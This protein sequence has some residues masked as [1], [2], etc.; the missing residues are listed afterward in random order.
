MGHQPGY[1]P[2]ADFYQSA[3]VTWAGYGDGTQK[4]KA[5]PLVRIPF[6]WLFAPC[7]FLFLFAYGIVALVNLWPNNL[8]MNILTYIKVYWI[9]GGVVAGL[10]LLTGMWYVFSDAFLSHYHRSEVSG[11]LWPT[12]LM[13]LYAVVR[14]VG[15]KKAY[16]SPDIGFIQPYTD[17]L[18][19]LNFQLWSSVF[20]FYL[21]YRFI[22]TM[23][24]P[25]RSIM[26][27]SRDRAERAYTGA[28]GRDLE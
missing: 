13:F 23:I 9:V 26:V 28:F 3:I 12:L 20:A 24:W 22:V 21:F 15:Y 10:M 19:V 25:E 16:P 11:F 1:L 17:W 8:T 5:Y 18:S 27:V 14:M 6:A 4:G 7:M 2:P